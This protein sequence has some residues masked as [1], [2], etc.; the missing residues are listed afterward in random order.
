MVLGLLLTILLYYLYFVHHNCL[1]HQVEYV[2]LARTWQGFGSTLFTVSNNEAAFGESLLTI[3]VASD[4][5]KVYKRGNPTV[6]DHFTY[7]G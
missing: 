4:G 3:G 6:M 1:I 7:S 2:N 5:I